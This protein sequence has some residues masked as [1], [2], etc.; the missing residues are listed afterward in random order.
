MVVAVGL[1][2]SDIHPCVKGP[3]KSLSWAMRLT[4]SS[5]DS[6]FA[7]GPSFWLLTMLEVS[8]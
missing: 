2:V 4:R 7:T 6:P 1:L 8:L 5:S 3:E